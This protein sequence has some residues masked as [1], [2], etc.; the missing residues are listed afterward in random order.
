MSAAISLFPSERAHTYAF[1]RDAQRTCHVHLMTD[2]DASRIKGARTFSNGKVSFVTFV[3][4]AAAE[5]IAACPEARAVLRDG[6]RP[7]LATMQDVTA[8]VLFD[9]RIAGQRCVVSGTIANPQEHSIAD[10]QEA[11]DEY[12]QAEVA[13]TGPFSAL[14]KLQRLP[15][16]LLRLVYQAV[17]RNP[18]RRAKFQG[19]FSV[20]SVGQEAVRTILPM[21]ASTIGLGVGRIVDTPQARDREVVIVPTMTLSLTFDHRV[22]DGALAAELLARIKSRLESWE[23]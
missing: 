15:L 6:W 8:K 21:I 9:K 7:R 22:L 19:T 14:W 1:L 4:K 23:E 10:I 16:P 3:V 20:T 17:M 13:K 12:K 11:M 2:V 18:L 5:V